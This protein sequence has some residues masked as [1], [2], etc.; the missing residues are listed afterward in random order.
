MIGKEKQIM[1]EIKFN[2]MNTLQWNSISKYEETTETL[3]RKTTLGEAQSKYSF[4]PTTRYQTVASDNR[5]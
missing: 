1:T 5:T 4:R 3:H 2:C